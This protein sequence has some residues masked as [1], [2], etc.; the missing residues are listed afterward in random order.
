MSGFMV[1][2]PVLMIL[3]FLLVFVGMQV[4]FSW[5]IVTLLIASIS[6]FIGIFYA[7]KQDNIKK[8]LA[9][10]TIENV[11]IIFLWISV[12]ILGMFLK[13]PYLTIIW[14]YWALF[15]SF[16]HTVFK[17][18]MF[19]LAG[20]VIERTGT[21]DYTK[22]WW[23]IKKFPFLWITFLIWILA[24]SGIM[25]LNGFNSEFITFL[26]LFKSSMIQ[27]WIFG[28]IAIL[29]SII[30][31]SATAVLS[32]ITFV[33]LFWI[34]FLGNKRDKNIEYTEIK[35]IWE[36]ISY[37][38]L[39]VAIFVLA[40]FPWIVYLFVSKILNIDFQWTIF[41]FWSLNLN[42][43]PIYLF[44][45]FIIFFIISYVFY[46][47]LAKKEKKMPVWNCGYAYIEP[48]TQYS[49]L[50]F[51]QPIRRIFGSLYWEKKKIIKHKKSSS[52]I[53]EFKKNLSSIEY[54]VKDINFVE[55]FYSK[56][57]D[58]IWVLAK[59]VK[60]LQ[61]WQVNSYVSYIFLAIIILVLIVL[62]NN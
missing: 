47:K 12:S 23:M 54:K 41:S 31:L 7:I 55:N 9:Y 59:K 34:T 29:I 6:A 19:M 60:S 10:S 13:N 52:H 62:F 35:S 17:W 8:L 22:L 28:K 24:I 38:V 14:I 49:G 15:H 61:N 11:W 45:I 58:F 40:I 36:K 5:F 4:Q 21:Y 37:V 27:S 43:T 39:V 48:K 53:N 51:V 1:K 25:P 2:L 46:K 50:S 26:A 56:I 32:L 20:W 42:Y 33:K 30:A 3:K 18:L 57:L 16:N 44:L